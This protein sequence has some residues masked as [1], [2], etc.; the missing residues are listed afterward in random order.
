MGRGTL[1]AALLCVGAWLVTTNEA[2]GLGAIAFAGL[3]LPVAGAFT[4]RPGW[5]RLVM[6]I[7]TGLVA[8][9][10]LAGVSLGFFDPRRVGGAALTLVAFSV[11][12]SLLSTWLANGLSLVSPKR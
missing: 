4:C 10:G 6:A 3:S 11:L 2:F 7:Y 1:L 5:P 9:I 12:G 8:L